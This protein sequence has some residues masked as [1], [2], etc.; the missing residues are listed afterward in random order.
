M[1]LARDSVSEQ[2]TSKITAVRIQ[3]DMVQKHVLSQ[4]HLVVEV[5]AP[6]ACQATFNRTHIVSKSM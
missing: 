4:L 1:S 5:T 3:L 6:K 2:P